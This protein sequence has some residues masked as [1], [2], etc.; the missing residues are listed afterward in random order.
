MK[1]DDVMASALF[2]LIN[3][4]KFWEEPRLQN[5]FQ[6]TGKSLIDGAADAAA[7]FYNT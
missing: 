7:P 6:E 1:G 3:V 4:Q 2:E 5:A